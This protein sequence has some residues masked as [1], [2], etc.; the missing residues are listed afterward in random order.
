[1]KGIFDNFDKL[2][3]NL[4]R[5]NSFGFTLLK[6]VF[7]GVGTVIGA[8]IVAGILIAILHKT[9]N[10]VD[11]IPIVGNFIEKTINTEDVYEFNLK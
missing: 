4:E 9:I 1:M 2:N 6:G 10:T 11:E 7:W 5:Q 8:S 3:K